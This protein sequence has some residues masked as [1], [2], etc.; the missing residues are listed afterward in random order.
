MMKEIVFATH[1][2]NKRKEVADM[3]MD[4][5]VLSL[6]DISC[7]EDIPETAQ[8]LQGNAL[9]K[10]NYVFEKYGIA[11]FSDDTGLEVEALNG[12]PGIY[13]ARYAGENSNA[14]ANI[15]KLLK[16]LENSSNRR[17]QFRTV[18]ALKTRDKTV[19]FE[20][21]CKGKITSE[22]RGEKGFGYDP[23][24]IPETYEK[25]FAQMTL[26]EKATVSHRGK[27]VAKLITHLNNR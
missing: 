11:C 20:A 17:A 13:S 10:A 4:Y 3:L 16:N 24:F 22:K 2:E 6:N 27:A 9:I 1:N 14:E 23:I 21:V 12:A 7:A 8:T 26:Q 15:Q 25:T 18:I 19:F 5:K